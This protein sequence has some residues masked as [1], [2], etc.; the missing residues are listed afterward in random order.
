MFYGLKLKAGDRGLTCQAEY[1]AKYMAYMQRAE[2][3]GIVIEVIP[4]DESG[5]ID[6]RRT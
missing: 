4:N 5:A 2:R 3:D 1:A 6:L